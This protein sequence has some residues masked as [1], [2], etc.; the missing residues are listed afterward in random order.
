V[1]RVDAPRLYR[2]LTQRVSF[3]TPELKQFISRAPTL[4]AYDEARLIFRSHGAL[5]RLQSHSEPSDRRNGRMV[6]VKFLCLES[7]SYDQQLSS[8]SS[9]AQ[10]CTFLSRLLLTVENLY[11]YEHP[12][13]SPDWK[14]YTSIK[15]IEWLDLFLPFTAVKNLYL[16]EKFAP[17]IAPALHELTG[18]RTRTTQMLPALQNVLLEGFLPSSEHVQ[19]GIAQFISARQLANHP[20]ATSVWPRP[21]DRDLRPWD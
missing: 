9:L 17:R 6:E 10:F 7:S 15:N 3:N 18:G 5:V 4:G 1:A 20:V 12:Y 2:L 13:L 19:E 16:S 14:D 11:I 8:V 21:L